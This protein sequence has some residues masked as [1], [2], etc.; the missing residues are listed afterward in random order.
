MV[1]PALIIFND[2]SI[3]IIQDESDLNGDISWSSVNYE[4]DDIL[5]D[6]S[7]NV[8]RFSTDAEEDRVFAELSGS[9]TFFSDSSAKMLEGIANKLKRIISNLNADAPET[10]LCRKIITNIDNKSK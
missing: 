9:N 4:E 6:E 5:I 3:K 7:L 10:L 1:P 2:E 8:Y